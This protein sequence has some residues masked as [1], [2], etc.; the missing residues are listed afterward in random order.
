M[1]TSLRIAQYPNHKSASTSIELSEH[2]ID[3]QDDPVYADL[4][5]AASSP[6]VSPGTL[7]NAA[8]AGEN[9]Y[10]SGLSIDL[11]NFAQ[12][13]DPEVERLEALCQALPELLRSFALKIGYKAPSQMHYD[14]M[15]FIYNNRRYFAMIPFFFFFMFLCEKH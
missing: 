12:S 6:R 7:K 14:V 1:E 3:I 10:V 15:V 11:Y 8:V 5:K 2:R 13:L 9:D 4:Q